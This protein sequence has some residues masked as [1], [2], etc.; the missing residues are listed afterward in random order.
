M[1]SFRY[2]NLRDRPTL[3]ESEG[4]ELKI[5]EG[6]EGAQGCLKV[7][8]RVEDKDEPDDAWRE[9]AVMVETWDATGK[10]TPEI[11]SFYLYDE[12]YTTWADEV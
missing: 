2:E 1:I 3:R 8:V 5:K 6:F 9:G 10:P 12:G 7:W 11:R 4:W